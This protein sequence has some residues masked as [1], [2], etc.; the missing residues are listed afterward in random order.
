M[1]LNQMRKSLSGNYPKYCLFVYLIIWVLLAFKPVDR[2]DWFLENLLPFIFVPALILTFK[3][4]RF[5][6]LSYTLI[7]AFLI[8]HSVGAHYAYSE[9]PFIKSI[10]S[11]LHFQRDNYDRLVHFTFGLFM[12][13]PIREFVIRLAGISGFLSYSIPTNIVMSFSAAYEI[14]EWAVAI[15]VQP[16]N[17]IAWLGI[18]GDVFDAEKDM[19][20]AAT[21]AIITMSIS[22][23]TDLKNVRK[24]N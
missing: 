8:L 23:F 2:L 19:L 24:S 18:Q 13:Y 5:S 6:N 11:I 12:V 14:I 22:F 15:V 21:G 4:L 16:E 20:M 1:N 9:V 3:K 7:T 17:A 10:F